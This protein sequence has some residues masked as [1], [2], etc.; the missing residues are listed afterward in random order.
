MSSVRTLALGALMIVGVGGG[1][2]GPVYHDPPVTRSALRP[3]PGSQ[4]RR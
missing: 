1:F 4:R 3:V 2:C